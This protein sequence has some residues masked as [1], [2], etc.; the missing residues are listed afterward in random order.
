MMT[1]MRSVSIRAN[2]VDAGSAGIGGEKQNQK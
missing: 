2:V 1:S